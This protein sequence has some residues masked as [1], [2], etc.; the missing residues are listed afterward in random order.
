MGGRSIDR[1]HGAGRDAGRGGAR[2]GARGNASAEDEIVFYRYVD[3]SGREIV[4]NELS[5]VPKDAQASVELLD[6]SP[7]LPEPSVVDDIG[8]FHLPSFVFGAASMILLIAAAFAFRRAKILVRVLAFVVVS[9]LVASAYFGWAMETAGL[10]SG[11]PFESPTRAIDEANA[12]K[13][14]AEERRAIQEAIL[15]DID[16][17]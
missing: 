11:R 9:A 14:K 2:D 16:G 12:A 1:D 4:T 8:R 15:K 10:G 13:G 7:K 3:Q 6:A 17:R 5:S